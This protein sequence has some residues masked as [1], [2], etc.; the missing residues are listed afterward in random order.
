MSK[1]RATVGQRQRRVEIVKFVD[2]KNVLNEDVRAE[3]SMGFF[4]SKMEDLSGS[5]TDEGKVIHIINRTYAIPYQKEIK[6]NGEQ[7]VLIDT[8][9]D[10]EYSIY[11]VKEVGR[12]EQL[13]L[14]CSI[15]E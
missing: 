1:E 12:K 4:Y 5:V 7:M 15:R 11:Y 10:K 13:I 3:E 8:Q 9:E 14:K 2:T 6:A